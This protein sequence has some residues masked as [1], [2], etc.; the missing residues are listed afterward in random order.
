MKLT[1]VINSKTLIAIAMLSAGLSVE[2]NE[3]STVATEISIEYGD[4]GSLGGSAIVGKK[5]DEHLLMFAHARSKKYKNDIYLKEVDVDIAYKK[6]ENFLIYCGAGVLATNYNYNVVM[7]EIKPILTGGVIL[8]NWGY[9]IFFDGFLNNRDNCSA[10]VSV[11]LYMHEFDK[12]IVKFSV[13]NE[14]NRFDEYSFNNVGARVGV[15]F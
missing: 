7:K 1:N 14:M 13:Y 15:A 4:S 5:I 11:P 9:A 10:R 8:Q 2:A 12:V 3:L 6:N